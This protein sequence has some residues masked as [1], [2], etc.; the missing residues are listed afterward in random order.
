LPYR[1]DPVELKRH[2]LAAG[3]KAEAVAITINRTKE[4]LVAY[5]LGRAIPPMPILLVL[6]D[7]YGCAPADV[8]IPADDHQQAREAMAESRAA[9][10]LPT[11]LPDDQVDTA[12]ELLRLRTRD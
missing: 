3:L 1:L 8:L 5:E 4:T 12:A 10:G 7:L 2:R 11:A 6:C 9:Q